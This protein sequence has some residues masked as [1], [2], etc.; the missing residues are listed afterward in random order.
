MLY[1]LLSIIPFVSIIIF[2]IFHFIKVENHF[3]YLKIV[4]PER[5]KKYNT[6]FDASNKF[7]FDIDDLKFIAFMPLFLRRRKDLELKNEPLKRLAIKIE[8]NCQQ[9]YLSFVLFAI[10]LTIDL[11]IFHII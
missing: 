8:T 11:I 10:F 9:E 2:G 6:Y 3:S 4:F 1:T 7:C 5:L